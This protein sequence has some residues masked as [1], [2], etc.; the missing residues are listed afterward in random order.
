MAL[1]DLNQKFKEIKEAVEKVR[2]S[3]VKLPESFKAEYEK[4]LS[5]NKANGYAKVEWTTFSTKITTSTGK[6]IFITNFWFYIASE[7]S[8]YLDSLSQQKE[9]FCKIYK[10]DDLQ[11]IADSLRKEGIPDDEKRK[12]RE[13]FLSNELSEDSL[14]YFFSFVSDYKSWGGGKTIDRND[15]YVSPLLQAGNL[16][17]ET[18]SAIAEIAKQMSEYPSLKSSFKPIFLPSKKDES[19]GVLI[20]LSNIRNFVREVLSYIFKNDLSSQFLCYTKE[21]QGGSNGRKYLDLVSGVRKIHKLFLLSDRPLSSEDLTS[22]RAERYFNE[23]FID[24]SKYLYLSNQWAYN[25]IEVS[26]SRDLVVFA[27]IFNE[28]FDHLKIESTKDISTLIHLKEASIAFLPLSKPFLLLAGISGTGKTRFVREQAKI[29]NNGTEDN[30]CLVPVRPDWHEPSDLLGYVSRLGNKPEYVAT[31]VLRFIVQAWKEIIIEIERDK[32]GKGLPF[33]WRGKALHKIKP[34][35]LC[36]DEMNLAPVEQYFSDYLSIL[37]T[38]SW[39]YDS[40]RLEASDRDY[41]YECDPLIKGELFR[42]LDK[43][44]DEGDTNKPSNLLAENLG[45]N[46]GVDLER[47]I[48]CYFL[49]HGIA[50][51]FNL[52]VAGTVNM[53]ETTHGF[54]RK[55][56]DR[57][58]SFDFGEFFPNEIDE[59]FQPT[60]K[61]KTLSYP[62]Y[63]QA[64]I[65][66]FKDVEADKDAGKTKT[67]FNA[68]ND[69]LKNTP[70]ELAYRAFNELCLSV[71]SFS[72]TDE[73]ELAAVFD[74]FLMCK[75]LPRIEGDED[76]LTSEPGD[77][78]LAQL[79][80]V[81]ET[82]LAS[83]WQTTR[84][85]LLRGKLDKPE[86]VVTTPCR[87]RQKIERMQRQLNNGF[88]SFWP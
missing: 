81:L 34:F 5:E 46:L 26:T 48:W 80:T 27:S 31:D 19:E 56:I 20:T 54:S 16:L 6:A 73:V 36:L 86:E 25:N 66:L 58:L 15:Y 43:G 47:D 21:V 61:S 35:W 65:A 55:V 52:I 85:D 37:E 7:L 40:E 49:Q 68:I 84:P 18:Q 2:F 10:G 44:F 14:K 28:I 74:D 4:Y 32:T 64:T 12:I 29:S 23:P 24:N 78:V 53:D 41:I 11:N 30:Y 33:D 42:S 3:D 8:N 67:F 72:P 50:I 76:K 87:S 1:I 70:F 75:V 77:N 71:I 79:S 62:V 13:Y 22:G 69:V 59:F 45:L 82:E 17:A 57:A 83:I 9:I 39:S 38:R 60:V 63:S 51:P 88:T